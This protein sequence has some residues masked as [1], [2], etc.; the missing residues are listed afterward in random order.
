MQF[1]AKQAHGKLF[2]SQV[3]TLIYSQAIANLLP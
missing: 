2:M 1:W 3:E